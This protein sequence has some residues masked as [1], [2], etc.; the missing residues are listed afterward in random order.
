MKLIF[1]LENEALIRGWR[2]WLTAQLHNLNSL[3]KINT[4]IKIRLHE[5]YVVSTGWAW[6][7]KCI[8]KF[9]QEVWRKDKHGKMGEDGKILKWIEK[10]RCDD[11]ADRDRVQWRSVLNTTINIPILYFFTI[12][13]TSGILRR[14]PI[15]TFS[16]WLASKG[17]H[18]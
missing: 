14:I 8:Q 15:R 17:V 2:T 18:V 7:W 12:W 5:I 1:E 11:V 4:V 10:T 3:P 13:A 9:N 16:Y 6:K